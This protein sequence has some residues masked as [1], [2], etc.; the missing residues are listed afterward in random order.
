MAHLRIP[1]QY[2]APSIGAMFENGIPSIE[3]LQAVLKDIDQQ[4]DDNANGL[5]EKM[6]IIMESTNDMSGNLYISPREAVE[7]LNQC[8]L[9]ER[10]ACSPPEP[11]DVARMLRKILQTLDKYPGCEETIF[12]NL[13]KLSSHE[14]IAIPIRAISSA[15]ATESTMSINAVTNNTEEMNETVWDDIRLK[16]RRYFYEKLQMLPLTVNPE[17]VDGNDCKRAEYLQS[18]CVLYPHEEVWKRYRSIRAQQL[19]CILSDKLPKAEMEEEPKEI[20]LEVI[21]PAFKE[22]V[23]IMKSMIKDDFEVLMSEV[24]NNTVE[25]FPAILEL[26]LDRLSEAISGIVDKVWIDLSQGNRLSSLQNGNAVVK[27][28]T[29]HAATEGNGMQVIDCKILSR[30]D[31]Y[32]LVTMLSATS[33]LETFIDDLH[34]LTIWSPV[35]G[36]KP[37]RQ[38]NTLRGVLKHNFREREKEKR[39]YNTDKDISFATSNHSLQP[40][41]I[42]PPF[43]VTQAMLGEDG[44]HLETPPTIRKIASVDKPKWEWC[45]NYEKL[46]PSISKSL[47]TMVETTT[48][49]A[50]T[51]DFKIYE[52]EHTLET[53]AVCGD[54]IGGK[55]DYPKRI[56]RSCATVIQTLDSLLPMAIASSESVF[57]QIRAAFTESIIGSC[58]LFYER[59]TKISGDVPETSPIQC[60]YVTLSTASF[61]RCH[62]GYYE[63]VLG[64]ESRHVLTINQK[65][66][67]DLVDL[68]S[69][70]LMEYQNHIIAT[71]VLQDAESHN[72]ADQR[73][74]YEDERCSFAIQMWNYHMRGLQHD[75][76]TNCPPQ[77]AQ[78]MFLS[79]LNEALT[80]LVQRYSKAK[81][82]YNRVKQM[83][84]D[85]T[86]ILLSTN[87]F[88]WSCSNSVGKLLDP[89][90]SNT[91]SS[92]HNLCSCLLSSI[93]VVTSPL[94]DLYK[95]YKRGFHKK[96]CS[97]SSVKS[98][99]KEEQFQGH[100]TQWLSW[101][102]PGLFDGQPRNLDMVSDKVAAYILL[103]LVT[104]QP[105]PNLV[106]L[107]QALLMKDACL[108]VFLV[109][110]ADPSLNQ[111]ST[112]SLSSDADQGCRGVCCPGSSCVSS[113]SRDI[114]DCVQPIVDVLV[115]CKNQP[116][117]LSNVLMAMIEKDENLEI[118][119][120]NC[121]PGKTAAIPAWLESVYEAI[122]P[123]VDR[124]IKSVIKLLIVDTETKDSIVPSFS[125]I[126]KE[127]PCG[128][129]PA[130]KDK[131]IKHH[132]PMD[133]LFNAIRGLIIK[134]TEE[135][136]TMPTPLCVFFKHLQTKLQDTDIR[137][138]H[139]CIGLQII[140]SCLFNKLQDREGLSDML[141]EETA[142][143]VIDNVIHIADSI[144]PIL[145][146]STYGNKSSMS[147]LAHIFLKVHCDWLPRQIEV[148]VSQLRNE[149]Y[150]EIEAY[151]T[152]GIPTDFMEYYLTIQS[153]EI[154]NTSEGEK[155]LLQVFHI[156]KNNVKWFEHAMEIPLI[157]TRKDPPAVPEFS[158]ELP[159]EDRQVNYNP[160]NHVNTLGDVSFDQEAIAD[161][162]YDWPVILSSD[163]GLSEIG[164][165]NLLSHRYEMQE[166]AYLEES[167][168]KPVTVLKTKFDLDQE[169]LV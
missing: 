65:L 155:S 97:S 6:Q 48:H 112:E 144:Y 23:E 3:T 130:N 57:Q 9:I 52:N 131:D 60:L 165:R 64:E 72:W 125:E 168:K 56:T 20:K 114:P 59:L 91:H 166:N 61:I 163:L 122:T 69:R 88:L 68:I 95:M 99:D 80:I 19:E 1:L 66:F 152:E 92:I 83:R 31:V 133:P 141:N 43:G 148:I 119:D 50:L 58:R 41:S 67:S 47:S 28:G 136:P 26:Y 128:C 137:T 115:L 86:A 4:L 11:E 10:A 38:K 135:I 159:C 21:T 161:F 8:A 85:I 39:G 89:M 147:K 123:W 109:T 105:I 151:S 54:L 150:S 30:S 53:E 154:C 14:G 76:F 167:E 117:A 145:T 73:A 169:E 40:D 111:G 70:N 33:E 35:V 103:K 138:A 126:L 13:L 127:L 149:A 102:R 75:L 156:L 55:S 74:F 96:K 42:P 139:N 71:V 18:L 77:L 108:P 51:A 93:V 160:F 158:L 140:A 32:S 79:I 15:L 44:T 142:A 29:G 82:S 134:L 113:S 121:I 90:S 120:Q 164:F 124:I 153:H 27:N 94:N 100:I 118:F 157:L 84:S 17:A 34:K 5:E 25:T 87:H 129:K 98:P 24:F 45:N 36:D 7:Q 49:E 110:N 132:G 162:K 16:L 46:I 12:Q 143:G 62:L 22:V 107:L 116:I 63:K 104:S 106:L 2:K 37:S 146:T 101:L 81:P 78:N